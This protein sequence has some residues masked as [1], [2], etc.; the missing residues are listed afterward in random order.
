M[1]KEVMSVNVY[2]NLTP[3]RLKAARARKMKSQRK[4]L[5]SKMSS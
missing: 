5:C 4:S 1:L 3:E 2:V